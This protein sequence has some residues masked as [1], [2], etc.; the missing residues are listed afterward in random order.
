MTSAWRAPAIREFDPVAD[1]RGW[2][3]CRLLSFFD[4]SYFDDV[5]TEP[6]AFRGDAIRLVAAPDVARQLVIG[7][8]DVEIEQTEIAVGGGAVATIDTIAVLPDAQQQGIASELLR[9]ALHRLPAKVTHI[10]AWT[11]DDAAANAWYEAN[12]FVAEQ[13]Y[14]HVYKGGNDGDAGFETPDG[15]SRPVIAFMHAPLEREA[16]MRA[17]F[18]R[19]HVCRRY[20]RQL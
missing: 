15:L 10:D 18:K 1:R 17:R 3:Q 5:K 8:I 14:L 9:A 7:V 6:T 2:L 19:V 13:H 4:S 16:E 12:D 11:R 20:V